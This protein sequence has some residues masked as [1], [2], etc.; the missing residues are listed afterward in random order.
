MRPDAAPPAMSPK[1]IAMPVQDAKLHAAP[2]RSPQS[3][4]KV[5]SVDQDRTGIK[6]P[7]DS[8][9]RITSKAPTK[10]PRL[11]AGEV[12]AWEAEYR[13]VLGWYSSAC[14][15]PQISTLLSSGAHEL[16][17]DQISIEFLERWV[18]AATKAWDARQSP[19]S[20]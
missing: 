12:D 1:E 17:T 2:T 7:A 20:M 18:T 16:S 10:R 11:I 5:I 4:S 8:Q 19:G 9:E 14:S 15:I 6:R 13:R 3:S